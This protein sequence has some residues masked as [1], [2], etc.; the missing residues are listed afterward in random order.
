MDNEKLQ[1]LIEEDLTQ[2]RKLQQRAT[3]IGLGQGRSYYNDDEQIEAMKAA[4]LLSI[5]FDYKLKQLMDN[6]KAE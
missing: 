1:E 5:A 4:A 3:N 6:S 2:L